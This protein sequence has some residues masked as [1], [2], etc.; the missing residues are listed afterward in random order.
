M[1]IEQIKEHLLQIPPDFTALA[2]IHLSPA[3]ATETGITYA[4]ECWAETD[5]IEDEFSSDGHYDWCWREPDL[6]PGRHS[7]YLYEVMEFLLKFGLDPSYTV[8]GDYGLMDYICNTVNG[9]VAADTLRLLF[10]NG[11]DPNLLSDSGSIY[12]DIDFDIWFGALEMEDRRRYD[13]FVHC[14][15]VMMGFGGKPSNGSSPLDLFNEWHPDIGTIP[16]ELNRL[17][18]HRNYTFGISHITNR[19]DA[20]TIHI[21]NKRTYWEVARI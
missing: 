8:S 13:S 15:M 21:F 19:G 9:Y 14:W 6:I 7:T 18:D 11:G 2:D 3:E 20:P 17:K 1:N 5:C 4:A 16:F 12:D 10:E